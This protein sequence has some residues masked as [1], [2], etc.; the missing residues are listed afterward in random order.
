MN[1]KFCVGKEA[2]SFALNSSLSYHRMS[3]RVTI[4]TLRPLPMFLGISGPSFCLAAEAFNPPIKKVTKQS[5]EKIR[6]RITLNGAFFLTNYTLV[7]FGVAVVIALL[8]PG[9]L[10]F[11]GIVCLLWW[12]HEYL[13]SHE[14]NVFG[15]N[16]GQIMSIT[17]RSTILTVITL[18]TVIGW[19]LIPFV[20]FVAVSGVI[21]LAHA[22]M[23][24]PKHVER[25]SEFVDEGSDS[26]EEVMVERGDVI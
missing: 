16:M 14:F 6:S 22:I 8:H 12:F 15:Q 24:D 4:D 20:A 3:E 23:R 5:W 7:A 18:V 19:C 17:Q 2:Y 21:I 9:M 11:V 1:R 13:I 26:D 25:S 10:L